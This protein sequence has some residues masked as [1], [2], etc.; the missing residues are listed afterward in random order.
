MRNLVG[1]KGFE[2]TVVGTDLHLSKISAIHLEWMCRKVLVQERIKTHQEVMGG[3]V[4]CSCD[5][6]IIK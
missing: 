3:D 6:R 2:L 4:G 5:R 1:Y